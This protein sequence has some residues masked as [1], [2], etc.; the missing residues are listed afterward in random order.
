MKKHRLGSRA[1][2]K[3]IQPDGTVFVICGHCGLWVAGDM[4]KHVKMCPLRF[5]PR[6]AD[7]EPM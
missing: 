2:D 5:L 3:T 7:G 1:G 4:D 6:K